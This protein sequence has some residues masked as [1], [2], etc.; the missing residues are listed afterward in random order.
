M[1]GLIAVLATA[2]FVV[3]AGAAMANPF[4]AGQAGI[5]YTDLDLA[6]PADQARLAIRLDNAAADVCGRAFD[7][8]HPTLAQQAA[9][10]RAEVIAEARARIDQRVAA[11]AGAVRTAY[12]AGPAHA[13]LK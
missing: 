10:C 8:I 12:G 1:N 5:R 7:R 9:Q 4:A 2:S 13:S 3:P 11:K 6:K